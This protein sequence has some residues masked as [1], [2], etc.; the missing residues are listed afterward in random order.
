MSDF[1][2]NTVESL[3]L[4]KSSI[5]ELKNFCSLSKISRNI[6][7]SSIGDFSIKGQIKSGQFIKS[8]FVFGNQFEN[9]HTNHK[10]GSLFVNKAAMN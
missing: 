4:W 9:S 10:D 6:E 7:S 3:I 8:F 2:L 1:S 5:Q